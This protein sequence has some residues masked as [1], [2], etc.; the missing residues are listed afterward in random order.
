MHARWQSGLATLLELFDDRS[1]MITQILLSTP[2]YSCRFSQ[3]ESLVQPTHMGLGTAYLLT[4]EMFE[5]C[6]L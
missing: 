4:V 1:K 2:R 5:Y 6:R 3:K